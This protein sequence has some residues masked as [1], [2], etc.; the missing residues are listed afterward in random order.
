MSTVLLEA[1]PYRPFKSSEE[2]LYAMREDLAE[3]M[4]TMYPELRM[5]VDN[6]MDRLDTGVALCKHANN[7]RQAAEE[8][9]ARRQARN[10]S[11]TKSMTSGLAGPILSMGNVHFLPAA[12]SGTFFARDNVSNFIAWCRKSLQIFECLLFETDDLIMRK[13]E[14]HVILCLLEVARRGAKFGMLA[15]MLVQMERQIDR[16]IAAD[17]KANGIVCGTQTEGNSHSISTGTEEDLFDSDSEDEDDPNGPMLMYGPQPQIVTNDLKSLDEMVR[18]LVEKCTCPSQFPMVRVSEGKYRIGDTK[19]LIFVRILRSHVMVRV[20]G[21]WDTLSHYLDKHDPCRCKAQHRSSV[22]ARLITKTNHLNNGIELHKAQVVYE[23][24]PTPSWKSNTHSAQTGSPN[25]DSLGSTLSPPSR[26]RS[27]SRSPSAQRKI[28]QNNESTAAATT[29]EKGYLASP[30]LTRRSMSPSP[31]RLDMKKK[32]NSLDS[33]STVAAQAQATTVN[34]SGSNQ[35]HQATVH[36][37]CD[38]DGSI[39][40]DSSKTESSGEDKTSKYENISDNGSEISDEGYRS[41]GIIQANGT[42]T[43]QAQKRASLYSQASNEDAEISV[44]LEQTTSDSQVTPTDENS[45]KANDEDLTTISDEVTAK[46]DEVDRVSELPDT[47]DSAGTPE[48]N[49]AKSGVFITDDEITID[50][51]SSTGLR[52]TGFSENLYDSNGPVTPKP[53]T[54]ASKIPKSPLPSRRKSAEGS[55]TAASDKAST[56]SRKIPTYRSVRKVNPSQDQKDNTWS[57]RTTK[58]RTPLAADTF[59]TKVSSPQ[60]PLSRNSPVRTSQYDKNGRKIKPVS[61]SVN[62][63]PNKTGPTSSLAQQLMEAAAGAQNDTQII[64]KVKQLLSKYSSNQP[65]PMTPGGTEYDD[66]TTAWVNNNGVVDRTISNSPK[67]Q[68]KR[69][70]TVSTTSEG[71]NCKEIPSVMSPRR[72][73]GASKIPAPVR[74]NTG[75]Y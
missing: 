3:W 64:E 52:K 60:V 13:N 12:K 35:L 14:K 36:F 49:F 70:S 74:S 48:S 59:D 31:R 42:A 30:N 63:S 68:S 69:S 23:R 7:V 56:L 16:E 57:G 29:H 8:Y 34:N 2:Y 28:N 50:I 10:K 4:N 58:Q 41:L 44:H 40:T 19:V 71:A 39:I 17:N 32:Q 20:G 11:M 5:N 62:T 72:D 73:K 51:A 47:V 66:F 46:S 54:T 6:F 65:Q 67:T 18:D 21:G 15:P 55:S 33:S 26:A 43:N 75:L 25:M 53:T 24:S 9:L 22:A 38:R 1:R 27:R 45:S 37:E 61:N